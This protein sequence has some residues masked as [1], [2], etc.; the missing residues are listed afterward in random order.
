MGA[1][2]CSPVGRASGIYQRWQEMR[3]SIRR[4]PKRAAAGISGRYVNSR[5]GMTA[6]C[7]GSPVRTCSRS[8][9]ES[10]PGTDS[11]HGGQHRAEGMAWYESISS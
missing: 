6:R 3:C 8:I 7:V 11:R 1:G 5:A 9:T 4:I 2:M 10:G